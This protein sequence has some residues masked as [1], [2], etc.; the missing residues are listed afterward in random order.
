M[1]EIL[2]Y[3]RLVLDGFRRQRWWALGCGALAGLIGAV[4]VMKLPPTYEATARVYVD[5][6]TILKPLMSGIAVQP[7]IDQQISMM[8]RTLISRPN[9]ERVVRMADLD[10][11]ARTPK[12]YEA[13]VNDLMKQIKI[14][15]T[16]GNSNV[17]SIGFASD[18]PE[19]AKRVVQSLLNI[20]VES[21][22]GDKRRDSEQA[23]K[24]IDDQIAQY[25]QRLLES[26]NALKEFKI[27][28][29][30]VMPSLAQDFVARSS[31]IQQRL[32][33]ARMELREAEGA[34]D[35]LRRQVAGESQAGSAL[36]DLLAAPRPA[37]S[38]I[39]EVPTELDI[40]IEAL[41][42]N[43]DGMLSKYT[44]NHPDVVGT[45]RVIEQLEQ[46]RAV[47]RAAEAAR[48]QTVRATAPAPA[49][50]ISPQT[51]AL[52]QMKVVVAEAEATVAS[53][54][55]RVSSLEGQLAQ[56][57]T[58]AQAVPKVEAEYTQLMRD[59]DVNKKSY[60]QLVS[61]RESAKL[62]GD[63]D[64]QASVAQFRIVDPPRVGSIPVGP[65][66]PILL[67]LV[68]LASIALGIGVAYLRDQLKPV[69][70][71]AGSLREFTGI[72]ILGSVSM[73]LTSGERL[74]TRL[75]TLAFS[76]ATLTYVLG[77]GALIALQILGKTIV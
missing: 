70:H 64:S 47:E 76:G 39:R 21:N 11:R 2:R 52:Q 19:D 13:L 59:Y 17:Y 35:E 9:V 10:H 58:T 71:D 60:D 43:L 57:R 46:Q 53:L 45:R 40:R 38:T 23:R 44:D 18:R 63:M 77:F 6:Q 66:R 4:V 37:E 15:G 65:N 51:N 48:R 36:P 22:L 61:R 62:S 3:V 31:E 41:R 25:E 72:P 56:A 14:A 1:A 34:R 30:S 73:Q 32:T 20:F 69:F 26:E 54:R 5:T 8:G 74:R 24:F 33:Q 16:G 50:P 7:N 75:A 42:K 28:N 68:L 55:G 27:R 49:A 67:G 12:E 29:M